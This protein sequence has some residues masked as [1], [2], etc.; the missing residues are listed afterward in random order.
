MP[1]LSTVLLCV[2]L[3][4]IACDSSGGN[5]TPTLDGTWRGSF[6]KGNAAYTLV[7]TLQQTSPLG[8]G[9]A[10]SV[11]GPGRL[12]VVEPESE[13]SELPLTVSGTFNAPTLTLQVSYEASRPGQLNG[14]VRE[15][16][17]EIEAELVGG[18]PGFD[19]DVVLLSRDG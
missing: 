17:D 10:S 15:G 4:C 13:E 19:G 12:V 5:D 1:R 8:V 16:F 6:T 9:D 7:L 3:L 14:T 2:L 11:S 18:G